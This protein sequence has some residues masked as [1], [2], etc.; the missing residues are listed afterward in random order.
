MDS[1]QELLNIA[2]AI[3][4]DDGPTAVFSAGGGNTAAVIAGIV[5]GLLFC[6]LGLKVIKI[7]SGIIGFAAGAAIGVAINNIADITG[8]TS[9]IIIFI[10]AIALAA[11]AFF[12]YRLGVLLLTLSFVSGI[13]FAILGVN[14]N[15]QLL[16]ILG[17]ALVFG[18][19][20]MIFVEP[21][22]IIITSIL[23]GIS[24]GTNI[25]ALA[26]LD[27]T[28]YIGIGISALFIISG[29]VVQFML[30]SKKAGRKERMHAE[31]VRRKDSMESE[32]EKARMLL[33]DEDTEEESH[34][35]AQFDD[36]E[37][38][39]DSDDF[40]DPDDIEDFKE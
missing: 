12:L 2:G 29:M 30:H 1:L 5:I 14:D 24:A 33:D 17:V 7:V 11:L 28:V 4:S 27:G 21:G 9:V 31:K 18:I 26:G 3:G 15:I 34:T 19:L 35:G 38:L 37:I 6:F 36:V 39:D 40:D 25:A 32:V 8:M 22:T 13:A 16:I 20:A 23:G 10:C